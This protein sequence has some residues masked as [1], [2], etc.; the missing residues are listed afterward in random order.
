MVLQWQI[1]LESVA[2]SVWQ[3]FFHQGRPVMIH[4]YRLCI[5]TPLII[6]DKQRKSA[7]VNTVKETHEIPIELRYHR[8]PLIA[9][10]DESIK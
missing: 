2:V 3:F 9:R 10:N 4:T 7:L 6:H 8:S 5:H 1:G